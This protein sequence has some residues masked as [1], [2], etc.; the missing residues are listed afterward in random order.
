MLAIMPSCSLNKGLA[1]LSPTQALG[2][3]QTLLGGAS[4]SALSGL[5]GNILGNSIMKEVLPPG[6]SNITNLLGATSQGSKALGLLNGAISS[7]LPDV[8]GGILKNATKNINPSDALGLLQGGDTG[9]TDFLKKA[10]GAKLTSAL[11]PAITQKLT[12]NGGMKAIK[13]AL[14]GQAAG[15]LGGGKT[16]I[17]NLATSGAVDGLFALMG[18][19]EKAER[20]NPT[21][22]DLKKIFGK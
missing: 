13:S 12:A 7:A 14:G 5:T 15:L 10:A 2:A 21:N 22:P 20:A 17:A 19:A 6:L 16:T 3:V 1:G 8:A 9:A 18:N 4:T 11:L